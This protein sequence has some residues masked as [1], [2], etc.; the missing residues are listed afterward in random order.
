MSRIGKKPIALPSGCKVSVSG[1]QVTVEAGSARLSMAK[2]PE[3]SV[4]VEGDQVIV[5]RPDD[6][7][8]SKAMHGLT[9]ALISN[10]ITGVTQGFTRELEIIGVGWSARVQGQTVKLD[11][12]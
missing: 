6:E 7:R 9:R 3:I 1:D 4:K 2:R 12:G 8:K 11:V 5:E 10:M